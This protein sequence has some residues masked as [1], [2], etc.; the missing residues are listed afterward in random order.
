MCGAFIER[1]YRADWSRST[2]ELFVDIVGR[3][4]SKKKGFLISLFG[5]ICSS[6]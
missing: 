1:F 6:F 4:G 2:E 5:V 3:A